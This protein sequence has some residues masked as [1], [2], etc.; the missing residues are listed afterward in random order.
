MKRRKREEE[1]FR[2]REKREDE[3]IDLFEKYK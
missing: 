3:K 1:K 2:Q